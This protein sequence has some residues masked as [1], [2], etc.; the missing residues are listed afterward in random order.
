MKLNTHI[1]PCLICALALLSGCTKE[2]TMFE[3]CFVAEQK[4][5]E[6][7]PDEALFARFGY[8]S[9]LHRMFN[10]MSVQYRAL[11]ESLLARL[12]EK[13]RLEWARATEL[14]SKNPLYQKYK[15]LYD[16]HVKYECCGDDWSDTFE[17][18]REAQK[19]CEDD[20]ECQVYVFDY[21]EIAALTEAN[22][23][24]QLW[25]A[26]RS[27]INSLMRGRDWSSI[28]GADHEPEKYMEDNFMYH[29]T[30]ATA[31]LYPDDEIAFP[32][33]SPSESVTTW[34]SIY[35]TWLDHWINEFDEKYH[36][37]F[38]QFG[39]IARETCNTRGLYE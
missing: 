11:D 39:G 24:T 14:Q 16:D 20:S 5:L 13:R 1:F 7:L 38:D 19:A 23:E 25:N 36:S 35:L 8:S 26:F 37:V 9:E 32:E 22:P 21:P 10:E 6:E 30:V 12:E 15:A 18:Y 33:M 28:F 3:K 17:A 31:E 27:D 34:R 4:K 2:P 29:L